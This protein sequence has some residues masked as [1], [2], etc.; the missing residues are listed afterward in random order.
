VV[1]SDFTLLD[2]C[3]CECGHKGIDIQATMRCLEG[4]PPSCLYNLHLVLKPLDHGLAHDLDLDLD[5]GPD[6]DHGLDRQLMWY[7]YCHQAQ[8]LRHPNPRRRRHLRHD[9]V[10][11]TRMQV[12]RHP[13]PHFSTELVKHHLLEEDKRVSHYVFS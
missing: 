8:H 7:C 13:V 6:H 12:N 10:R 9:D 4:K 5:H 1:A 2:A 3:P 11:E